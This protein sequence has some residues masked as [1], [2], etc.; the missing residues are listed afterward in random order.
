MRPVANFTLHAILA[1]ALAA[2]AAS[3]AAAAPPFSLVTSSFKNSGSSSGKAHRDEIE[4]LS[5]SFGQSQAGR[6]SKVD[7]F[8][9]K[10]GVKNDPKQYGEWIADVE[11]PQ[12]QGYAPANTKYSTVK[13]TRGS[14]GGSGGSNELKM[15]DSAGSAAA[16]ERQAGTK[17]VVA[18]P[19][20]DRA[21]FS[22]RGLDIA[23]VDGQMAKPADKGSVWVRVAT[24]W[25]ACRVR[26]RYPSLELGGGRQA[27]RFEDA[28][29]TGCAPD[30]ASFDYAKVTVRGWDPR[31]KQQ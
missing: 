24:P 13:L 23:R 21:G 19:D 8:T 4:V 26:A 12:Q 17:E 18:E 9:V 3:S 20:K 2:L 1:A 10:Q 7:G 31:P 22:G 6:V 16:K 28:V 29:V 30:G 11:R 15:E 25:S 27:Y 5:Y 14:D